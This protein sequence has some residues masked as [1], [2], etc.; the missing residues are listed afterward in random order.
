MK[1]NMY[2]ITEA[3]WR[4]SQEE[5]VYDK[6][7]PINGRRYREVGNVKDYEPTVSVNGLQVPISQADRVRQS[8]KESEER[9]KKEEL[10]RLNNKPTWSCPFKLRDMRKECDENCALYV[11]KKC[12]LS[13]LGDP[14]KEVKTEG[15]R[16]PISGTD[17]HSNCAMNQNGCVLAKINSKGDNN[18][19]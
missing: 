9:H 2:G 13:L 10:E 11:D 3:E 1:I 12:Q 15:K 4:A 19:D 16:C 14:E 6:V 5:V 7:D 17:C 8:L 18:N